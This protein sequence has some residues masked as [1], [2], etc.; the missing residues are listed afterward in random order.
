[1]PAPN[2]IASIVLNGGNPSDSFTAPT[3]INIPLQP[4]FSGDMF[5]VMLTYLPSGDSET[6]AW[7]TCSPRSRSL[8]TSSCTFTVTSS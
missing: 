4:A 3:A 5:V 6:F 2:S 8:L 1:M 7:E